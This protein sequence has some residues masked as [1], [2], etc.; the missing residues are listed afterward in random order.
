MSQ[1]KRKKFDVCFLFLAL[2]EDFWAQQ[3][4]LGSL[5][6]CSSWSMEELEL[7]LAVSLQ[8]AI[9]LCLPILVTLKL[10][11]LQTPLHLLAS[12]IVKS[13]MYTPVVFPLL[14]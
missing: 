3:E 5:H 14:H 7:C 11:S 13:W 6:C 12:H 1:W 10:Q 4:A 9:T 2:G 8:G